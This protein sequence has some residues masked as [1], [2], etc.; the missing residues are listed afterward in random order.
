MIWF[1]ENV[2]NIAV[3]GKD[4]LFKKNHGSLIIFYKFIHRRKSRN[5]KTY[6]L[7]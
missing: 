3:T 4:E 2:I 5:K 1:L 7:E 6:I